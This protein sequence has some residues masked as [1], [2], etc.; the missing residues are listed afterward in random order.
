MRAVLFERRLSRL[1]R[2]L[3]HDL[4]DGSRAI[5]E[6]FSLLQKCEVGFG[7]LSSAAGNLLYGGEVVRIS[8][9][10]FDFTPFFVNFSALFTASETANR[11]SETF[12]SF[13]LSDLVQET[14]DE[15]EIRRWR[16]HQGW[17][18]VPQ[19]EIVS[20]FNDVLLGLVV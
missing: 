16:C 20:F 19:R 14:T 2:V 5:A 10:G 7:L 3:D 15:R 18:V 8:S 11:S 13:S 6:C 9:L 17:T 4:N 12:V 1:D